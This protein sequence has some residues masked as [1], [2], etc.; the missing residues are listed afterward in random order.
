MVNYFPEI[1][2]GDYEGF[3]V[4]TSD[5]CRAGRRSTLKPAQSAPVHDVDISTEFKSEKL[6]VTVKANTYLHELSLLSD[7]AGLG[8]QVDNQMAYLLPGE[9]HKFVVSG[10]KDILDQVKQ[11]AAELVWSHNRVVNAEA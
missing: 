8:T 6:E 1:K 9:T 3:I 5:E 11:K 7:V 4:A 2:N 10:P